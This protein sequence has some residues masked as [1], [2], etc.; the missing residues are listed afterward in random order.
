MQSQED[1]AV[2]EVRLPASYYDKGLAYDRQDRPD[3]AADYY[4]MSINESEGIADAYL[5]LM[6][7]LL[8]FARHSHLLADYARRELIDPGKMN[9]V[10]ALLPDFALAA[11]REHPYHYE[12]PFWETYLPEALYRTGYHSETLMLQLAGQ[13]DR[14]LTARYYLAAH[15]GQVYRRRYVSDF[16]LWLQEPRPEP[17]FRERWLQICL[18][19]TLD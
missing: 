13:D 6:P 2:P 17:T 3:E 1:I 18:T 7:L 14:N 8:L 4:L 5:N 19:H 15:C 10:T 11:R 16:R 12:F 9:E